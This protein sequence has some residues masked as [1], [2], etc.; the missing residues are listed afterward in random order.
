V[1]ILATKDKNVDVRMH[2]IN[3]QEWNRKHYHQVGGSEFGTLQIV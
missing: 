1:L 3:S 2:S